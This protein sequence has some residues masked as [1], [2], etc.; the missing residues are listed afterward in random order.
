VAPGGALQRLVRELGL[1]GLLLPVLVDPLGQLRRA[2]Q[3]PQ[4]AHGAQRYWENGGRWP[5]SLE[6]RE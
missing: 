5:E 2:L 1:G 4:H 6:S 3:L